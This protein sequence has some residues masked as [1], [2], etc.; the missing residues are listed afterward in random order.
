[1]TPEEGRRRRSKRLTLLLRQL[2]GG[3]NG[4]SSVVLLGG[5]MAVVETSCTVAT[6]GTSWLFELSAMLRTPQGQCA[7]CWEQGAPDSSQSSAQHAAP[8]NHIETSVKASCTAGE[9]NAS[10]KTMSQRAIG[11]RALLALVG[12]AGTMLQTRGQ[13]QQNLAGGNDAYVSGVGASGRW[14]RYPTQ[15]TN[16]RRPHG[17]GKRPAR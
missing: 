13:F 1:M 10:A 12:T 11:D 3:R 9:A 14:L 7:H 4:G 8:V 17:H 2:T 6:A 5:M 15:C 16:S